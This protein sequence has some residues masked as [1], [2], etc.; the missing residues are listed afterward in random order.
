MSGLLRTRF[1]FSLNETRFQTLLPMYFSLIRTWW[2]VP[3]VQGRPRSVVMP[4]LIQNVGDLALGLP[5]LD[6]RP[7][8][9]ADGVDLLG[10]ARDQDHAVGLDALL[11]TPGEL[12]FGGAGLIDQPA[13]QAVSG[14]AALAEAEF[15]QPALP[16]EDLDR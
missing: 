16:R 11:L 4:A 8:H 13:A 7:V 2:T 1:F 6:K 10:R 9:P 3:R 15:D 14:R 12:A 5:L